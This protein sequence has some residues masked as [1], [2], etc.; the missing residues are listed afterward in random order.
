M[1]SYTALFVR[2][3]RLADLLRAAFFFLAT[4]AFLAPRRTL[5]IFGLFWRIF[6]RIEKSYVRTARRVVANDWSGRVH[7]IDIIVT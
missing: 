1:A 2:A 6:L 5:A 7:V 4:T 3:G